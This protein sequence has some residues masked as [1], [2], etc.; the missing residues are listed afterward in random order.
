[1][2]LVQACPAR[3]NLPATTAFHLPIYVPTESGASQGQAT[4]TS[5][6]SGPDMEMK[7]SQCE[8]SQDGLDAQAWTQSAEG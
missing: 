7:L 5:M 4:S 6:L 1:M 8:L 3:P 2:L